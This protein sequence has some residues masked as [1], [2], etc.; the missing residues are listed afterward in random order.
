[1]KV[2]IIN[3][4]HCGIRNSSDVFLDNAEKFYNN[5]VSLPVYYDLTKKKQNY[6]I[7][8]IKQIISNQSKN[9]LNE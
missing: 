9:Y 7:K 1:M 5:V 4:T 2:V 8:S 3:D 6:I